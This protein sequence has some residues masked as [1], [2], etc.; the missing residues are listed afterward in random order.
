MSIGGDLE[1]IKENQG[2]AKKGIGKTGK[3]SVFDKKDI[4]L[5]GE[6]IMKGRTL[7]EVG[8][9]LG[10][11]KEGIRLRLQT[12]LSFC[13]EESKARWRKR[14]RPKTMIRRKI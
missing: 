7:Q 6:I 1:Y 14:I 2:R 4:Y 8:R 10:I 3:T 12:L 9:R 5:F 11:S 13:G